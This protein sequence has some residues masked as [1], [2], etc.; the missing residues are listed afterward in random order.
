MKKA[1]LACLVLFIGLGF[2][3]N[4][5]KSKKIQVTQVK[6]AGAALYSS[7]K[8]DPNGKSLQ[9]LTGGAQLKLIK[10]GRNRSYV[11][12]PTGIKGW[13]D[14]SKI[15][16]L[17]MDA[18][19]MHN[20]QNQEILGWLDNPSAVYILDN[21]GPDLSALPLDRTFSDEI[22]EPRDRESVERSNDEN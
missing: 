5:S 22:V 12:S 19:A 3:Q 18:G 9:Q 1:L 20:L 13:V 6:D 16:I 7:E 4:R 10:K 14:N 11:K 8:A 21:S 17:T 15:E 2:G